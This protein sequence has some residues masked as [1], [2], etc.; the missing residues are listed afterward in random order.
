M[1]TAT[2]DVAALHAALRQLGAAIVAT[3]EAQA[4]CHWLRRTD[5][6]LVRLARRVRRR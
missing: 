4:L 6:A 5:A 2:E 1:S 3:P